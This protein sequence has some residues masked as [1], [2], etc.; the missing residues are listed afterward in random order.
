MFP[1]HAMMQLLGEGMTDMATWRT[2]RVRIDPVLNAY[3]LDAGMSQGLIG[4][5]A[6][7]CARGDARAERRLRDATCSTPYV[8]KA[9][10]KV[11]AAVTLR[12]G[13]VWRGSSLI[14]SGRSTTIPRT[15]TSHLE[16][17]RLDDVVTHPWLPGNARVTAVHDASGIPGE[18]TGTITIETNAGAIVVRAPQWSPIHLAT[19]LR[20]DMRHDQGLTF[21]MWSVGVLAAVL[22]A[23]GIAALCG[24]T[25][26]R[27]SMPA[28][29]IMCAMVV[30]MSRSAWMEGSGRR[31]LSNELHAEEATERWME[32]GRWG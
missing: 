27:N 14:L 12:P 3:L 26:A 4:H 32:E 10:D 21:A 25:P 5:L 13:L 6:A 29:S 11:S 2:R 18:P 16:G 20:G 17:R 7:R 22:V 1:K 30:F 8:E 15:V 9:G 23:F 31:S 24:S 19:T 28:L